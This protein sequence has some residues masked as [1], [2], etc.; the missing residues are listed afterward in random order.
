MG[1]MQPTRTGGR[2]ATSIAFSRARSPPTCRCKRRPSTSWWS[3]SRPRGR[4][5]SKCRINCWRSPMR[6][7]NKP[8]DCPIESAI[9]VMRNRKLSRREL[10]MT[11]TALA[12]GAM[13][14]RPFDAFAQPGVAQ[15]AL[16]AR[17]K[18]LELDTPYVP[19]P[20]DA[21]EHH[22]SGFAKIICSAVFVTG[23]NPDFAAEN[24]GY[25]TAPYEVR[26]KLG[27]PVID[28]AEKA[29]HVTLPNG[30]TRTAK[31]LGSQGCVTLPVGQ[32]S[33]NFTPANVASRLPDPST[34]PWPMGDVLSDEPLPPEIDATKLKQAIDAAFDP[35]ASMTAAF[36]VTWRGRLI[37]E[38]YGNGIT[39]RTPLEGWSMGKSLTATLIGVLIKQGVYD[40]WQPAPIPEWQSAGDPRAKIRI[41][42]LM[43]MSSGLRIRAPQDPDYDPAG[44]YPDHLYL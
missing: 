42:D 44:P 13:V 10:L 37:A 36:V 4:S 15:G 34:Q 27:K 28:R 38:R 9:H 43:H 18:S 26:H 21:L 40:I 17:A 31:Y 29:V 6:G 1:L 39:A 19:P 11:S 12:A 14:M 23:L 5:A 2:P 8:I 7:S 24:V 32:R 41:G 35:S 25:F 30:V 3:T 22:A 20:G 33:V 16:I